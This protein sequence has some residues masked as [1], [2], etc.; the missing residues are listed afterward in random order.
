MVRLVKAQEKEKKKPGRKPKL[1]LED[2]ILIMLQYLREYRTYFHIGK[3]WKMSESNICR[4]VHKIENILIKSLGALSN[5]PC[6]GAWVA[7]QFA[8]QFRLP[9]KKELWQ[10][11]SEEELVVMDVMES[12]IERPKRRQKKFY[13]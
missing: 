7:P 8:P 10:S 2:Q 9:G 11:Y 13:T 4:I 12:Q 6:G 5:A 3:E 1:T